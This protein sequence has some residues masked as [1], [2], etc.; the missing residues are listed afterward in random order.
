M[1]LQHPSYFGH[2]FAFHSL[3]IG[4]QESARVNAVIVVIKGAVVLTCTVLYLA[5]SFVLIGMVNYKMMMGDAAPVATAINL[6]LIP[7]FRS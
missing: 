6:P 3:M 7:G 4:I 1:I 2:R 5:F